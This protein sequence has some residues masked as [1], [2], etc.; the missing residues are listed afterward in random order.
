MYTFAHFFKQDPDGNVYYQNI[1]T[2]AVEWTPPEAAAWTARSA[3]KFFYANKVTKETTW[4]RP[5]VLGHEDEER[6]ATYYVDKSG[7]TTWDKPHDALWEKHEHEG[8][9]FFHHG[10]TKESTWEVPANSAFAWEKHH[11]EM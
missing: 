11:V 8:M 10:G 4:N 9:E 6:G 3:N 5:P 2:D 7:A 1:V